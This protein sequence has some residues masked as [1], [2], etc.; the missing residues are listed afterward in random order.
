MVP[1]IDLKLRIF[2]LPLFNILQ[3]RFQ[4]SLCFSAFLSIPVFQHVL[5]FWHEY[6]NYYSKHCLIPTKWSNMAISKHGGKGWIAWSYAFP[7]FQMTEFS[8]VTNTHA[9]RISLKQIPAFSQRT[10]P[11]HPV[12]TPG[13]S[14]LVISLQQVLC[15]IQ[16]KKET[17]A[18]THTCLPDFQI[19]GRHKSVEGRELFNFF[20]LPHSFLPK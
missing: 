20:D 4:H 13:S 8:S 3:D 15:L 1:G 12:C 6:Q 7:G 17:F 16:R 9:L 2:W 14:E 19:H 18:R 10:S 5:F 11:F